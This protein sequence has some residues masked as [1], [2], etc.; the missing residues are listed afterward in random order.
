MH[1]PLYTC[2]WFTQK[3]VLCTGK[4]P[5]LFRETGPRAGAITCIA[6]TV[7]MAW[8]DSLWNCSNDR[9][10]LEN[11]TFLKSAWGTRVEEQ[12]QWS[13][14]R[15]SSVVSCSGLLCL[16]LELKRLEPSEGILLFF[17]WLQSTSMGLTETPLQTCWQIL[18]LFMSFCFLEH[19]VY[20]FH[21][22]IYFEN[23]FL[24]VWAKIKEYAE[25]GMRGFS[26]LLC[27]INCCFPFSQSDWGDI[28]ISAF[29]LC[30]HSVEL[31]RLECWWFA[32][33]LNFWFFTAG[34][35]LTGN[36]CQSNTSLSMSCTVRCYW[37]L[38]GS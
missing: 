21:I 37:Q 6:P 8:M 18:F 3:V 16:L 31:S 28:F 34:L 27:C 5:C 2:G 1:N 36:C 15:T 9:C 19:T 25:Q 20:L 24:Q 26:Y 12:S 23:I 4:Q 38:A 35:K 32:M 13:F 17:Y 11:I 33:N 7:V 22:F 29:G 30:V 14:I 10:C